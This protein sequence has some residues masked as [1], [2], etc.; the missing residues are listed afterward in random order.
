MKLINRFTP[1]A[2]QTV[3]RT[4]RNKQINSLR[5]LFD[6]LRVQHNNPSRSGWLVRLQA[7]HRQKKSEAT[8]RAEVPVLLS[9]LYVKPL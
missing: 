4:V 8:G 5:R 3:I 6:K 7:K 1:N 2:Q 9:F